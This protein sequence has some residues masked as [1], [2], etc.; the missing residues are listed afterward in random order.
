MA[1]IILL[2]L[3]TLL[4]SR[5]ALTKALS[6]QSLHSC[7]KGETT[8][9]IYTILYMKNAIEKN[10]K[11]NWVRGPGVLKSQ[12]CCF[13]EFLGSVAARLRCSQCRGL[14]SIPSQGANPPPPSQKKTAVLN[15]VIQVDITKNVTVCH[16]LERGQ[17]MSHG[18]IWEKVFPRREPVHFFSNCQFSPRGRKSEAWYTEGIQCLW[19]FWDGVA[20]DGK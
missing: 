8:H 19:S 7:G 1:T 13:R 16:K 3:S 14:S 9:T 5:A 12:D 20:K 11:Q 4:G 15:R 18:N 10:K 6:W 17:R 2:L